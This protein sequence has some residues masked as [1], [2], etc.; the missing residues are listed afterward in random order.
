MHRQT[1]P[2][3]VLSLLGDDDPPSFEVINRDG[4]TP[5]LLVCDHASQ[6]VPRVLDKLGMGDDALE[7]H[8]A[9]D[10]GAAEVSRR[11]SAM[12]DAPCVLAGYSRLLIDLNRPPGTPQ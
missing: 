12:L 6:E 4:E 8:I 7:R 5:L 9:Y 10:I 3:S 11:L 1:L 2:D